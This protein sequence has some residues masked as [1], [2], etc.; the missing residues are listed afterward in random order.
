MMEL[1]NQLYLNLTSTLTVGEVGVGAAQSL[2]N[3][4]KLTNAKTMVEIGF[5]RGSSALAF[6]LTLPDVVLH[7]LDIRP[8][9]NVKESVDFLTNY[10]P[11]R[12][13][14]HSTSSENLLNIITHDVDF[15]FIDGDHSYGAIL[16]DTKLSIQLNPKYI[17]YDDACHPQHGVDVLGVIDSMGWM[18]KTIVD[19]NTNVEGRHAST[20]FAFV[21]LT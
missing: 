3:Y 7:S 1:Y 20:G 13:F 19:C 5:N 21:N 9:K 18:H 16:R 4:A 17:L 8:Y 2:S 11:G 6:L 15:V 14:Y 12:F 10:F